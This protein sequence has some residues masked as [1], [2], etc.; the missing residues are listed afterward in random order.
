[1][2]HRFVESHF[3]PIIV[4]GILLGLALPILAT[5]EF[6]ISLL[7]AL[8]ILIASF[9]VDFKVFFE[10]LKDLRYFGSRF[11]LIKLILPLVVFFAVSTFSPD[12]ALGGLL[13][14][15]TPTGMSNI[16]L[17]DIFKGNNELSLSF[18]VISHIL[19]FIYIPA[20]VFIAT[21]EVISFDYLSLF[22]TLIQIVLIPVFLSFLIKSFFWDRLK[23]HSKYFSASTI[24]LVAFVVAVIVSVNRDSFLEFYSFLDTIVFVLALLIFLMFFGLFLSRDRKDKI[25]FSLSAFHINGILGLYIA[26]AFFSKEV[27]LVMVSVQLV[28][29]TLIA[30]FK[31]FVERYV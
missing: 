19:S 14:V 7:L 10:Y 27:V 2:V 24:L 5:L 13:L 16:V 30:F 21:K 12:L 23:G 25:A 8:I 3:A 26:S 22:I 29:D 18:S 4:L 9:K 31:V 6:S 17:S 1:M 28:L 15:A 20:L 11:V